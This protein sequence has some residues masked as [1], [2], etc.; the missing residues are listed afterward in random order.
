MSHKIL[1]LNWDGDGLYQM[2]IKCGKKWDGD[3]P[4]PNVGCKNKNIQARWLHLSD[5]KESNL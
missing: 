5:R 3:T 4:A 1:K 2:C